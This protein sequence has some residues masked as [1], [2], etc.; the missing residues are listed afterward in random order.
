MTQ[1]VRPLGPVRFMRPA[2]NPPLPS[3]ENRAALPIWELRPGPSLLD[4]PI[5]SIDASCIS[6]AAIQ[7]FDPKSKT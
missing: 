1:T 4:F 3:L 2:P 6:S 7:R 5:G